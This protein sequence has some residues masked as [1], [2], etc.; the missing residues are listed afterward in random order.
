M[1]RIPDDIWEYIMKVIVPSSIATAVKIAVRMQKGRVT[2][3]SGF[4]SAIISIGMCVLFGFIIYDRM[5]YSFAFATVGALGIV[6]DKLLEALMYK[7]NID[8]LVDDC[9]E[10]FRRKL[11]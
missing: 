5:P 10:W 9:F 7:I 4:L 11:K 8:G 2:L 3:L 6:S 1:E